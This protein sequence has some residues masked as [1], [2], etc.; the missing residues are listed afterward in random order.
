MKQRLYVPV[1]NCAVNKD[2]REQYKTNLNK[3]GADTVFVAIERDAFFARGKERA[4][5]LS[6]L[7]ENVDYFR[8]Q[9]FKVGVWFVALGTGKALDNIELLRN[10]NAGEQRRNM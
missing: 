6:H 8:A 9:G 5:Y 2:N 4:K 1:M 10:Y 7:K 3:L